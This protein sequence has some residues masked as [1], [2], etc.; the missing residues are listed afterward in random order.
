MTTNS[1]PVPVARPGKALNITLWVVQSLLAV[2]MLGAA[3][4]PKLVGEAT[5]VSIFNDMGLGDWFR[6]FVGVVELAGAIGLVIPR[7]ASAAGIGLMLL[8]IGAT[9]TNLFWID[10]PQAAVTT[11]ILGAISG[12]IA[13]GR[14]AHLATLLKR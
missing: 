7:L 13:W 4:V 9:F 12:W 10:T 11:V 3:A 2:F 1:S 5:A 14:R 8:M 6:Y